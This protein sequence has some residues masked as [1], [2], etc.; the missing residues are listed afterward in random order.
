MWQSPDVERSRAYQAISD[1]YGEWKLEG[2]SP[3]AIAEAEQRLAINDADIGDST[4]HF[5]DFALQV[6]DRLGVVDPYTGP[7]ELR[8]ARP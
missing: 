7:G 2:W 5:A 1:V 3:E 4:V 6:L 8:A